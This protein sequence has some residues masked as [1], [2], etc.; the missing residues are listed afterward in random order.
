MDQK[1]EELEQSFSQGNVTEAYQNAHAIKSMSANLGADRVRH[2]S[3]LIEADGR[4]GSLTDDPEAIRRL[5]KA[6]VEFVDSF[7][8]ELMD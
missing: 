2:F 6:Y 7:R 5:K 8:T 4:A 1:L 3:A